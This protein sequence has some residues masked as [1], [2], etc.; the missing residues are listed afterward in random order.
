MGRNAVG[1]RAI[2]LREGDSVVAAVRADDETDLLTVTEN[3]YGKRTAMAEYPVQGRGGMGVR[4]YN[5]TEKTGRL[6][7][8]KKIFGGEDILLVSDDGTI[9]RMEADHVSR[10]GRATQGVRLMRPNAGAAVTAV[11]RTEHVETEEGEAAPEPE[12]APAET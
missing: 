7:G 8:A 2:R 10:F 9:I 12:E 5:I 11:A 3:G 4:T 1:V 6:V